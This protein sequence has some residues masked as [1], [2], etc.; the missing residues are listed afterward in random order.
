MIKINNS[1]EIPNIGDLRKIKYKYSPIIS[2]IKNFCTQELEKN[3]ISLYIRGSV[4]SGRDTK[5]S[6]LDFVAIT[7]KEINKGQEQNLLVYSNKLQNE[8]KFINGFELA[9]VSL[10]Q[11]IKSEEYF[12]LRVN[13]KTSSALVKGKD[14]R[15]LLP[16]TIPGKQLSI[17][18]FKYTLNEYRGSIKYFSS[19]KEKSYLGEIKP[20]KFWCGWMMRV[21]S[22]SGMGIIMLNEKTYTND[23]IYISQRMIKKYPKFQALFRQARKWVI[24]PTSDRKKVKIFLGKNV[25][26]Y[27]RFWEKLLD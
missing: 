3:L 21:L 2:K 23:I 24:K 25:D 5:F 4:S 8:Y 27:F 16:K 13:L 22:R 14:I 1:G 10:K 17:K 20:V 18:M 11:L 12:N 9:T 15:N 7:K 6:D 19:S 26:I